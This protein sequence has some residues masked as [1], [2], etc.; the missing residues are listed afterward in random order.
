MQEGQ[1]VEYSAVALAC[2]ACRVDR[3]SSSFVASN[4]PCVMVCP[5]CGYR[6]IEAA[7]Q[8]TSMILMMD[9][10]DTSLAISAV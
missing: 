2:P 7:V 5:R 1:H 4:Q 6:T 9:S 10:D 3:V 8:T